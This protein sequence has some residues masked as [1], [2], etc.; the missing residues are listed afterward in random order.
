M[1]MLI[2]INP[3]L[4]SCSLMRTSYGLQLKLL[5]IAVGQSHFSR[6]P[7]RQPDSLAHHIRL[8]VMLTRCYTLNT[9]HLG[10]CF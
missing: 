2:V 1:D 10:G 8:T 4:E 7:D 3:V 5:R 6:S 9:L